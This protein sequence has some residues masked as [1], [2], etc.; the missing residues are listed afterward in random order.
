MPSEKPGAAGKVHMP[1]LDNP[2]KMIGVLDRPLSRISDDDCAE[3]AAYFYN[4]FI[5]DT[6]DPRDLY[7]ATIFKRASR[8]NEYGTTEIRPFTG[9]S[10]TSA[11]ML[12]D[13]WKHTLPALAEQEFK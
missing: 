3:L 12:L 11:T 5:W 2:S 13:I 1:F 8:R 9:N 4:R 6:D 10:L 7:L